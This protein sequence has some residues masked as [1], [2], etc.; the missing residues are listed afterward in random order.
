MPKHDLHGTL[1][2][3]LITN[4]TM[5][6]CITSHIIQNASF[7][8]E[9]LGQWEWHCDIWL[10]RCM[11]QKVGSRWTKSSLPLGHWKC[12]CAESTHFMITT[13]WHFPFL[14]NPKTLDLRRRIAY[15]SNW[16]RYLARWFTLTL[17][18]SSLKVKVEGQN[19]KSNEENKSAR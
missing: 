5:F 15:I 16:P 13:F 17:Y 10:K 3:T 14:G 7:E 12:E 19:S 1:W 11:G 4:Y 9:N 8:L 2:H 18:R 6:H